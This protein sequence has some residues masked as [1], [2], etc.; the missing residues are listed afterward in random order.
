MLF[1]EADRL[2]YFEILEK[3]YT[4]TI[5]NIVRIIF[6]RRNTIEYYTKY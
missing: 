2:N 4:K 6:D 3:S 1:S 5:P